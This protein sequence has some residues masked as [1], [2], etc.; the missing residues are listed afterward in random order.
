M[1][2]RISFSHGDST[3]AL[4]PDRMADLEDIRALPP[5]VGIWPIDDAVTLSRCFTRDRCVVG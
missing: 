2:W 4:S 3:M 1:Q 5:A